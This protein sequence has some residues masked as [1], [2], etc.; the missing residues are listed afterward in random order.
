MC[1]MSCVRCHVS[2][3]KC[4][5][6]HVKIFFFRNTSPF[7]GLHARAPDAPHQSMD[8]WRSPPDHGR[9]KMTWKGTDRQTDI[10]TSQL[11][12]QSGPRDN[13]VK[14]VLTSMSGLTFYPVPLH[15]YWTEQCPSKLYMIPMS[16]RN[17][18]IFLYVYTDSTHYVCWR[19]WGWLTHWRYALLSISNKVF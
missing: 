16:I 9:K 12:D 13:S 19:Y 3:V 6:S 15:K 4:H 2:R 5:L 18:I 17:T 8:E 7:L 10:W 11:L 1:H 14:N